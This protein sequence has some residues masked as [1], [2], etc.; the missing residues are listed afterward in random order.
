MPHRFTRQRP[1]HMAVPHYAQQAWKL[2]DP[3][4]Q[5]SRKRLTIG[6]VVDAAIALADA[7]GLAALSIRS[8]AHRLGL[9]PMAVYRHVE[10]REELVVLM[11]DVALG[12]PPAAATSAASWPEALDR[13]GRALYLCYVEHP[14]A[15]DA[16]TPRLPTTPNLA[17]WVDRL[18]GDLE[19]TGLPILDRM[20]IA[21]LVAG[22]VRHIAS[23]RLPTQ[24]PD[25]VNAD[26]APAVLQDWLPRFITADQFPFYAKVFAEGTFAQHTERVPGPEVEYGL[27]R[28][29]DGVRAYCERQLP[30]E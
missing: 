7:G 22:H 29:V 18:L 13:W 1:E 9:T 25:A 8:L 17:H 24:P 20:N 6:S 14:W 11:V 10:S 27:A 26:D 23:V 3:S 12:Q 5:S 4:P 30:A 2:A 16:P 21:L 19:P 15:L 28:I